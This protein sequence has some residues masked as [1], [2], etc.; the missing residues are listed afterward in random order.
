MIEF[1]QQQLYV[2]G[3]IHFGNAE[4]CYRQ[5]LE[6][7]QQQ[8]HFPLQINLSQLQSG[9]TLALAIFIRWLRHTPQSAGLVFKAVPEKMMKIIQSC[10]LEQDLKFSA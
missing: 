9:N 7:I 10:H 8:Q 2:S 5:G 1:K 3:E 4:H 6:V